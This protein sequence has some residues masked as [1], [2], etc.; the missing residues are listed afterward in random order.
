MF[1]E[2]KM[3]I[4]N[5]TFRSSSNIINTCVVISYAY[6]LKA[7]TFSDKTKGKSFIKI[8]K[9]MALV[10]NSVEHQKWL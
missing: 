8:K 3:I 4:V 7:E 1:K 6:K 5:L 2:S 10:L 9:I